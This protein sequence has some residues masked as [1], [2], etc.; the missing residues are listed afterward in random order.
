MTKYIIANWKMRMGVAEAKD[1]MEQLSFEEMPENHQVI[2]CPPFPLLGLVQEHIKAAHL[3]AQDCS[4]HDLGP[5]TG[6]VSAKLLCEM[7]CR[8]VIVG[9]SERRHAFGEDSATVRAKA[10]R[11][12][13]EKMI[14]IVCIGETKEVKQAG[15][16]HAFLRKQLEASLPDQDFI[17]AYEPVWA[18]GT[19]EVPS[20][21]DIASIH[22]ALKSVLTH[23]GKGHT[24][25]LYGGSVTAQNV[26]DILSLDA[27][28]GVLVGSASLDPE[29]FS[30]IM[31][32]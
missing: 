25:I 27:V 15:E 14:P 4:A 12:L 1:F 28:S 16:T 8:Y 20:L 5:F 29:S 22:G 11:A 23:H 10:H 7:G 32:G 30:N 21:E 2:L 26:S 6:D 31:R 19:G 3:G 13:D 17:L 24:P 18:I 9:H